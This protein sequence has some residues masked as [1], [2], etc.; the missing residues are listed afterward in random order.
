MNEFKIDICKRRFSCIHTFSVIY[1]ILKGGGSPE[2]PYGHGN[3]HL[4]CNCGSVPCGEYLFNHAN[5]TML[6]DWL[7]CTMLLLLLLL[8]LLMMMMMMIT[9]Q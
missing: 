7:E 2:H 5:G 1:L 6:R 8:L 4:P 3:C 9:K